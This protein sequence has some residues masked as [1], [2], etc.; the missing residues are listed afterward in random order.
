ARWAE[1]LW[2]RPLLYGAAAT[3]LLVA[4]ALPVLGL[5]T[6]MP[7]IKVVPSKDGSRVG[8]ERMQ[9][10]FGPGAPG[11]LQLV[12]PELDAADALAAARSDA[13]IASAARAGEGGARLVLLQAVPKTDPSSPETGATIERLRDA[14]PASFLVG[15]AAAEN[16]DLEQALA[17]ATPL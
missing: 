1:R 7:S 14:L 4:L 16:H 2:R 13:G 10:A 6:G 17:H 15:G 5:E 11:A 9:D 3:A 8:Y 12:G